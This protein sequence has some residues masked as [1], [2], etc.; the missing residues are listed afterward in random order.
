MNLIDFILNLAALLLWVNWRVQGF[1]ASAVRPPGV[2]LSG[3]LSPVG[4]APSRR[5]LALAVLVALLLFRAVIYRQFGPAVVWEPRLDLNL[6][7]LSWRS[8]L[9][10]RMLL[11]SFLSFGQMLGGFCVWLLL[12]S[13][14]N[15]RVPDTDSWQRQVRLHLG[16]IERLPAGLKVLLPFLAAAGLWLLANRWLAQLGIVPFARSSAQSWQQAML[17]GAA[18]YLTWKFLIAGVL[19]LHLM[20]NYLYLGNL[21]LWSFVNTTAR[22]LLRP[23]GFLPLQ[24]GKVDFA[25]VLG[26][27]LVFFTAEWAERALAWCFREWTP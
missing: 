1:G 18:V 5:W 2:N 25:P 11:F 20:N 16:R 26:I 3:L 24:R 9:L 7:A 19:V 15:S 6:I 13:A 17:L 21:A 8:D 12:L 27:A 22:N 4:S 23:L 10:T 14:V